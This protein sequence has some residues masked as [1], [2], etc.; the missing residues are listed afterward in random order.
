[1]LTNRSMALGKDGKGIT[2]YGIGTVSNAGS[3]SIEIRRR[4]T[5]TYSHP[6]DRLK[7]SQNKDT[8]GNKRRREF[9]WVT[10]HLVLFD[11]NNVIK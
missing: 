7:H 1:M 8:T 5:D 3:D 9:V 6:N 2:D 10:R 11:E 4:D